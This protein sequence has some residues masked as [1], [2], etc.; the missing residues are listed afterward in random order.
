L[1]GICDKL[2]GFFVKKAIIIGSGF[3]GLSLGIRLL[4]QGFSVSIFEKNQHIGGHAYPLK[5]KKYT[6]DMGPSLITAPD[7]IQKVFSR[8]GSRLEDH[9]E[10]IPLNPYYRIYFHDKT[11]LDYSGNRHAMKSQMARFNAHDAG[12]YD[13]FMNASRKIYEAVI[14]QGL[15]SKPFM[16][17]KSMLQFSPQAL[18]MGAIF[19]TY[20]FAKQ[21]FRDFRHRFIYSFHPLFIGGNPFR[22]PAIYEMIPYLEKEKGVWYT[23]GG[24]TAL[25][26][27]MGQLYQDMGGELY[28]KHEVQQ[29][30]TKQNRVT[31]VRVQDS[32]F[33]ADLVISNADFIHTYRDLISEEVRNKWTQKRLNRLH[34]SMSAFLIYIG[35]KKR[36]PQ[37]L[38]HT[39]ILSRRYKALI[40]DIFD[41]HVLPDDFSMY[42]HTPTRTDN[43]MAPEGCESMTILIPVTNLQGNIHWSEE[44]GFFA[45]KVL[46]FLDKDFGLDGLLDHIELKVLFTP[47]DFEK[48]NNAVYG[49]AWGVEPRLTQTAY[50]RPHNRSEEFSNLYLVGAS[51]HPGG[52]LPGCLLTAETTENIICKDFGV[53]NHG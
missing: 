20:T 19:P 39:L 6:F 27:A 4:S 22:A 46:Q 16:T 5:I 45:Q 52:G 18:R 21:Y 12:Q 24:M 33:P 14:P 32:F 38:H 41:R 47:A 36:F 7:V 15:G 49:S 51:T 17:A 26:Q 37:L 11:F 2:E 9:L 44:A 30:H 8:A 23:R 42:L 28:T 10:M 3:G 40:K 29:I 25:I 48:K 53:E 43:S 50:F 35:V 1:N 13:S 31:G 34:Y